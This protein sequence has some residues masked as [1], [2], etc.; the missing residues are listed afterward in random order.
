MSSLHRG[1]SRPA[2]GSAFLLAQLGAHAARR[3]GERA[4]ELDLTPPQVGLLRA[5]AAGPG[6]SQQELAHHLGTAA[7]RLVGLVDG[8]EQRGLLQ[9]R[10][11]PADRRLYELQLTPAGHALLGKIGQVARAHDEGML[12]PL[13]D[14]QRAQLHT[15]L[16]LLAENHHLTPGVHPGYQPRG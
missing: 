5:V 15:L 4:A 2:P 10:R 3:F 6:R 1:N 12:A 8:L 16:T 14:A 13:N 7:T 11:N 9:R